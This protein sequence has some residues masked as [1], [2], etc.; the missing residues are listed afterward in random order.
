MVSDLDIWRAANLLIPQHGDDAELDSREQIEVV[1]VRVYLMEVTK[2]VRN[3]PEKGKREVRWVSC[4]TAAQQPREPMLADICRRFAP[5][6]ER[7]TRL[8]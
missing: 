3:W 6:A 4:E 8:P 2:R 1:E 7:T 5:R